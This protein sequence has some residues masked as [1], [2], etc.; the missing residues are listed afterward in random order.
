MLKQMDKKEYKEWLKSL[1][2]G[3]KVFIFFSSHFDIRPDSLATIGEVVGFKD[4]NIMIQTISMGY[5]N[6]GEEEIRGFGL[7]DGVY[8]YDYDKRPTRITK[9][10]NDRQKIIRRVWMEHLVSYFCRDV[11]S[12]SHYIS[13]EMFENLFGVIT[14]WI[15][16]LDFDRDKCY[17][18]SQLKKDINLFYDG[19][20]VGDINVS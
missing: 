8:I 9:Y 18:E 13:D 7:K 10:D 17:R 3:D 15:Q 5:D 12:Q 6:Y 1:M 16:P 2:V 11:L 20:I 4:K 14:K 19:K